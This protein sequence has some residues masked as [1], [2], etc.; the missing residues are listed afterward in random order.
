MKNAIAPAPRGAGS[1]TAT[2]GHRIKSLSIVGGFLDGVTLDLA[3]G[4]NC[5][6]G[7]RG[8]GKTT[9]LELIRFVL[10]ALPSSDLDPQAIPNRDQGP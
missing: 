3:A 9:I 7:A 4:L 8:T 2:A 1:V 10:D 6:I 5:V